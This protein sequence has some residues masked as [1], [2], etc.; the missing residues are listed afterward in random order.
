MLAQAL[1]ENKIASAIPRE[2]IALLKDIRLAAIETAPEPPRS[3]KRRRFAPVTGPMS[4]S[5]GGTV[6]N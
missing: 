6:L 3:D 1:T 2:D 5:Q 4:Q